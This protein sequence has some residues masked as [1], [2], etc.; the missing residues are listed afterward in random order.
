M[1]SAVS[2]VC[3][4]CLRA[5]L[6]K[7]HGQQVRASENFA[8]PVDFET[9]RPDLPVHFLN[10]HKPWLKSITRQIIEHYNEM[11]DVQ[12]TKIVH[13]I[14]YE[15]DIHN[16]GLFSKGLLQNVCVVPLNYELKLALMSV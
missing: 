13:Y 16:R 14:T 9:P 4:D 12:M 8:G 15:D 7:D 1:A 3:V 2:S 6:M 11:E 10:F 5:G